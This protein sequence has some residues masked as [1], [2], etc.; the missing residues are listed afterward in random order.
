LSIRAEPNRVWRIQASSDL[1][2]WETVQSYTSTTIGYQF[3]DTAAAGMACRFYRV[4][5]E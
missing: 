4:A 2:T 5:S 1:H 3:P